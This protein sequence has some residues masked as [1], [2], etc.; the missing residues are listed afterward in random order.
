MELKLLP[1]IAIRGQRMDV[2][3]LQFKT[4]EKTGKYKLTLSWGRSDFWQ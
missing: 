4:D 3:F 1:F 2:I